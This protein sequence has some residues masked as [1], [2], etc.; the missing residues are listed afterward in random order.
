[1]LKIVDLSILGMVQSLI[2]V[3]KE[4]PLKLSL[5]E[6]QPRDMTKFLSRVKKYINS[7]ETLKF[8][9]GIEVPI[10]EPESD[11]S[12]KQKDNMID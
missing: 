3:L 12:I 1:M 7:K 6:K 10:H 8:A 2:K 5:S 4:G 9:V 11:K